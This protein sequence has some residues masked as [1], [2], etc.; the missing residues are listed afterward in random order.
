MPINYIKYQLNESVWEY[1]AFETEGDA[2]CMA[3]IVDITTYGNHGVR[4]GVYFGQHH[5]EIQI[6]RNEFLK[7]LDTAL[8]SFYNRI[9][10]SVFDDCEHQ[11]MEMDALFCRDCGH[12]ASNPSH[13]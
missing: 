6:D 3:L 5:D 4:H 1:T 9:K 13:R 12:I 11:C 8:L 10:L 2:T 7:V